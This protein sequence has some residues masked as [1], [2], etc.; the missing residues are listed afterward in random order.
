MTTSLKD[1]ESIN[2]YSQ[3]CSF[4]TGY[5]HGWLNQKPNF[6]EP[7]A[8][9]I[10]TARG[11]D[12]DRSRATV[13]VMLCCKDSNMV[14][15]NSQSLD[16]AKPLVYDMSPSG[17]MTVS[18]HNSFYGSAGT[19]EEKCVIEVTR[20]GFDSFRIDASNV[21]GAFMGDSWFGGCSWSKDERFFTYVAMIKAEKPQ[22]YFGSHSY[23][24]GATTAPASSTKYN[25]S[26]DWG[27][28]FAGISSLGIFVL[29]V[30]TQRIH[31]VEGI[32]TQ[33]W[34][35]GQPCLITS[36]EAGAT[37]YL[38]GYTAFSC[39]PRK[40]GVVYCFQRPH[41]L[42]LTDITD[43]LT[44][45]N[46][47]T[48]EPS[49][50]YHHLLST[51]LKTAR[52][53]RCSPDGSRVAFLG[54]EKG[55]EEH[56]GCSELFT[57]EVTTLISGLASRNSK[58]LYT[59]VVAQVDAPLV[60]PAVDRAT[61]AFPGLYC[62]ALPIHC[63]SSPTTVVLSSQWTSDIVMLTVDL[64]TGDIQTVLPDAVAGSCAVL[65]V[66][67]PLVLYA[68][69]APTSPARLHVFDMSTKAVRFSSSVPV[70]QAVCML[71]AGANGEIENRH[72][73]PSLTSELS[74][75][76]GAVSGLS[77]K[78]FS[79][80]TDGI[81]FESILI[82]P[83]SA[84]SV[85]ARPANGI[86]I[87]L[88]PH[89]GPHSCMSTGYFHAYAFLAHQLGSA[90]LHVNYRGSP[91]FGQNSV[92]SLPGNVGRNDVADMMTALSHAQTLRVDTTTGQVISP[93]EPSGGASALPALIDPS[94][95]SVVGG[96]HGGFLA[97][98]LIGQFPD[99]FK[100]AAMRNPVTNIAGEFSVSDIPD[101][102]VVEACGHGVYDFNTYTPPSDEVLLK[103]RSC[104][105]IHYVRN[106]RTPTLIC[107]GGKDRRVPPSQGLEYHHILKA[108]GV[109]TRVMMFPEDNHPIDKPASEAEHWLAIA[110]WILT[111]V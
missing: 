99:V 59:K 20:S 85:A 26:E 66:L 108:Q 94:R 8:T 80:T 11:I 10:R 25:Y 76:N 42:F 53:L 14:N 7:I 50:L 2:E 64:T 105:P 60:T 75:K 71:R 111:H 23:A 89:G 103:M 57:A 56:N 39:L 45:S 110:D 5:S 65:N 101:W 87:V 88:V 19:K 102:C 90:V 79:H 78:V 41:S 62:E 18:L 97:G 37:K 52:S 107:L 70:Q 83:S 104:S 15:V 67:G 74:V 109:E 98:H 92:H 63:F 13:D 86:P 4:A 12:E 47:E 17:W 28:R 82:Y 81:L 68:Q 36:V 100:A 43:L 77:W 3:L 34:T 33:Q 22:T 96:S 35:V 95:V 40:L 9:V 58:A 16:V 1:P 84:R 24:S 44:S 38:L 55:F 21:H 49:T 46:S 93:D 6:D 69:S 54:Q 51:G 29:D 72:P 61:S 106:V 91:G 30:S 73:T 32:D 27:E 48:K 31:K